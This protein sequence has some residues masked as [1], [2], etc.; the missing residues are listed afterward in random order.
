MDHPPPEAWPLHTTQSVPA[1][2]LAKTHSEGPGV[3]RE[4]KGSLGWAVW[5]LS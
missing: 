1:K 5:P 3:T 4:K 2:H